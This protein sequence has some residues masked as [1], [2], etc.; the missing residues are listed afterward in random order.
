M[1]SLGALRDPAPSRSAYRLQRLWL[2]PGVRLFLRWGLPVAVIAA[3]AG[4]WAADPDRR[5]ILSETAAD[6]RRD[7][8]QRPEFVV[9]LMAIEGATDAVA[10]ELR[11][12]LPVDL[13]SS[14]FDLD[15]EALRDRAEALDAVAEAEV[16]VRP[17][18]RL[19]VTV[20]ERVPAVVWR[21]PD[22]LHLLDRDGHRVAP[23]SGRTE[24]PDLPLLA[25]TGAGEAVPEALSLL[26]TAGPLDTRI[27]G[28]LRVGER[29]WDL[30]L[31]RGQR[32]LLPERNPRE[33][34]QRVIAMHQV[35]DLLDRDVTTV[36]MR[37][38]GRPTLRMGESAAE[39]F[40]ETRL[41]RTD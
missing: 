5:A 25:G 15:L 34:L 33:A 32:L 27:R 9:H 6:I 7:I 19:E 13:P 20:V 31:D 10:A 16:R 38:P 1:R 26:A 4:L 35:R 41:P 2:T 23:L 11:E 22:G 24:R 8:A 39:T 29:R 40:R 21:G 12:M 17:G 30:V 3:A 18:G 14:S 37:N 28:L 36:D